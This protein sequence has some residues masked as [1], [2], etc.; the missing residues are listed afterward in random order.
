MPLN[1]SPYNPNLNY[2]PYV[3]TKKKKKKF[4][5][6]DLTDL[7][8][9][10]SQ[11]G[12]VSTPSIAPSVTWTEKQKQ[13]ELIK[14][15]KNIGKLGFLSFPIE[16][17]VRA[18]REGIYPWEI[19]KEK[20][21][22]IDKKLTESINSY[23]TQLQ[24]AGLSKKQA[25]KNSILAHFS[26]SGGANYMPGMIIK[27]KDGTYTQPPGV[28]LAIGGLRAGGIPPN[29][30][31]IVKTYGISSKAITKTGNFL[32]NKLPEQLKLLV[33]QSG[34]LKPTITPQILTNT[35]LRAKDIVLPKLPT[36][37][38]ITPIEKA[39]V[40]PKPPTKIPIPPSPSLPTS[41]KFIKEPIGDPI[42]KLDQLLKNAKP[43][44]KKIEEAYTAKR[45]ERIANVDRFINEKID[46]VGGEEGYAKILSKLKGE[47]I[48]KEDKIRF[49]PIKAGLSELELKKLYLKVWK[50]PYLDNWEKIS[51]AEGLTGLL[52]GEL[53]RPKQL[54]L[55]EEV[56]GT[57]LIKTIL[58]KRALGAKATDLVVDILNIPRALL[59]TADMSGFLR[60]GIIPITAHPLIAGKAIGKTFQFAF[61]PKAFKQYFKDLPKDPLYSLM[62]KSRIAITDPSKI[63]LSGKEE[64][65]MTTLPQKIPIFGQAVK[66]AERSYAGF[67]TKVRVDLF[68]SWADELLSKGYSPI[69]D[70]DLFK[71]AANVVNTFTARGS[72]GKLNRVAPS[73]NTLFFSV[74]L[75]VA[76]FNSLN[77]IWYAKMPKEIRVKA[78]SDF[79]KFVSAGLATLA[80]IKIYKK[81]N[82]IP[83]DKLSVETDPRSSDFGKIKIEDTRWDIWGGFQQWARVFSQ[84]ITGQRKNTTTGEIVSLNKERYPFTTRKDVLYRFIEGKLA[85]AAA[86]VN[87]LMSGA[88]TFTGEDMTAKQTM[89]EKLIPMYIQD[90]ADAYISGG[91]GRAVGAG[92][93]AFFGIGVQTYGKR[94][95]TWSVPSP[96]FNQGKKQSKWS[97]PSL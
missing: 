27:K 50:H 57:N 87:E 62:R 93:P 67:L 16:A 52:S 61:S 13:Q 29:L 32:V 56:Y 5:I 83:D 25:E 85:P 54:V 53:P 31:K 26:S 63:G 51:A 77:P 66:F 91:M 55:L 94:N 43:A 68:K 69:K 71:A 39:V 18:K 84:L 14:R 45:A 73:L 88:K 37:K 47:L 96:D 24:K 9:L 41:P 82:K 23:S 17:V 2:S 58:S 11:S 44:R 78:I 92:I 60:Q 95:P 28:S 86:L 65:F 34:T 19:W 7:T 74:R 70:I 42:E 49:E 48:S 36:P 20:Q 12:G 3:P 72:I 64:T 38:P 46:K 90:I 21:Q 35:I 59:A 89:K 79:A 1:Y 10:T 4:S 30:S 40:A 6:P 76:R 22:S 15:G 75:N 8:D 80:I 33:K 81:A 97:I